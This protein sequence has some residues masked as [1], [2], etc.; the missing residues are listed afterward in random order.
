LRHLPGR[1]QHC[2]L[3]FKLAQPGIE[4]EIEILL[5]LFGGFQLVIQRFDLAA[6]AGIFFR[7]ALDLVRQI[8]LGLG[9]LVESRLVLIFWSVIWR[10][11]SSSSNTRPGPVRH[12]ARQSGGR[13]EAPHD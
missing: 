1:P 12:P 11:A 8:Q 4:I 6:Q 13:F 7:L 2:R 10:R 3:P 9:L 5:A